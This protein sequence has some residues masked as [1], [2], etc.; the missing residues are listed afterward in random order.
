MRIKFFSA[1]V[2]ILALA[3]FGCGGKSEVPFDGGDDGDGH[4][5]DGGGDGGGDQGDHGG[6][7]SGGCRKDS[8]CAD[9]TPRCVLS[10]GKCV[11]CLSSFDCDV[12][13]T[14]K[15]NV[16][17]PGTFFCTSDDDCP[18]QRCNKETGA[19]VECLGDEDCAVDYVCSDGRCKPAGGTPC[20][21]DSDCSL[22]ELCIDNFCVTGCNSSRDCPTGLM[23]DTSR[24]E[25]GECVQCITQEDCPGGLQCQD[26]QC[27]FFCASDAD[28]P[29]RHCNLETQLC[30]D[31]LEI[32][33]CSLGT[34]CLDNVCVP[35]CTSS[36][37]CPDDLL[38]DTH[39]GD[40][41]ACVQCLEDGDCIV[42]NQSCRDGVCVT[43]CLSDQDCPGQR[44]ETVSGQ[45]VDCLIIDDCQLGNI[46]DEFHQCVPGCF[47]S[48]DCPVPLLCDPQLGPHGTC[49]ECLVDSDCDSGYKCVQNR[50]VQ[51]CTSDNDCPIGYCDIASGKCVEC[52]S[53]SHCAIGYVCVSSSCT[54]GCRDDNG[55]PTGE[56]CDLSTTPGHCVDCLSDTDCQPDGTCSG[57][58]C[59]YPGKQCGEACTYGAGECAQGLTCSYLFQKC[60]PIC[61]SDA[62]CPGSTCL[63]VSTT[64]ICWDCPPP[65]CDP[66]CAADEECIDG[67]CVRKCF[68]PCDFGFTCNDGVCD[69]AAT[70]CDPPCT[71]G[72]FCWGEDCQTLVTDG[73][74]AG[75]IYLANLGACADRFE[76]SLRDGSIGNPD[77]TG[78]T[79][80]AFSISGVAPIASVTYY[81]A[82]AICQ[83]TGKRLCSSAE[84]QAL[85]RGSGG[86][87]YPYGNTYVEGACHSNS[88]S[89]QAKPAGSYIDCISSVGAVDMSGN[90]WEWTDTPYSGSEGRKILGGGFGSTP[91]NSTCTTDLNAINS[92]VYP[93]TEARTS[94]G[95][96]CC[97]SR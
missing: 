36:R 65:V 95:F 48:R 20:N 19:C 93:L 38:C 40:H 62:D 61:T 10:S 53:D 97:L 89:S 67:Q 12:N 74:P 31:C 26:G 39:A 84:W 88:T 64:G 83:N 43:L 78:V 15:S 52:L 11:E 5:G 28:C 76:A 57:G 17:E 96:R 77:G 21:G 37:D 91:E 71:Q 33:H 27:L 72:E 94:L 7:D 8:D 23:C 86:Y 45:C 47:T 68:P 55:C 14:C 56:K 13:E 92:T 85:C 75:M 3:A 49:V 81:Q 42:T 50:C 16:C 73:C 90:V 51:S 41:G 66:P 70:D 32:S 87:T 59:V 80:R 22:G 2:M 82:S 58:V 24:G 63:I 25:H 69:P 9:P 46:C 18:G 60:L 44:C 30:V 34:I 4:S 6:G 35:G 29:G 1:A 54:P 79:A